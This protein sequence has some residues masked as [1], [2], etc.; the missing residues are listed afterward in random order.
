MIGYSVEFW[1]HSIGV[2][3]MLG[4]GA[5]LLEW[6]FAAGQD[7]RRARQI[8]DPWTFLALGFAS[9]QNPAFAGRIVVA[10]L[11]ALYFLRPTTSRV[12]DSTQFKKRIVPNERLILTH[13]RKAS[14]VAATAVE[15]T[16]F[17]SLG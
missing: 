15:A 7:Y 6:L 12:A 5:C 16:C 8:N 11:N 3:I 14:A 4:A 2:F 13:S 9:R 1:N 17:D 10:S